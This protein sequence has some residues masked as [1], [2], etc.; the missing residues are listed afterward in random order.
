M[1]KEKRV[2]L[3]PHNDTYQLI[4][5]YHTGGIEGEGFIPCDNCHALISRVAIVKSGETNK[6]Y[7]IGFDCAKTLTSIK[8][9]DIENHIHLFKFGESLRKSFLTQFK[10]TSIANVYISQGSTAALLIMVTD[11]NFRTGLVRSMILGYRYD[12]YIYPQIKDLIGIYIRRKPVTRDILNEFINHIEPDMEIK[13][14][15]YHQKVI[16]IDKENDKVLLENLYMKNGSTSTSSIF[17][18][19]GDLIYTEY[20]KE[21]M[22]KYNLL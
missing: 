6:K 16:S 10:Q 15:S 4:D 20:F 7:S 13:P 22:L 1:A 5:S 19:L 8:K 21:L 11:N 3:L 17:S 18:V 12:K 14:G 9:D 2:Y